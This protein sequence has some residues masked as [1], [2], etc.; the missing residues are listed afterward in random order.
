MAKF[1]RIGVHH[2]NVSGYTSKAWSVRRVGS[3]AVLKWGAV[4]VLGAGQ[5]RRIYWAVPPR[6]K[7]VRC[8]TEKRANGY[9]RK[10]ISRRL[11]H[12]YERLPESVPIRRRLALDNVD[13]ERKLATILFVDIVRS[14]EKAARMGD[15]RWSEV[16]NH[17]YAA[18]RRELR[19]A[20]GKE[21]TTT[22]DGMLAIFK[23]G[24]KAIRCASAIREAV[25]T[26]GLEI[27]AGLHAGEYQMIGGE[28]VGIAIHIGA[29]VA[30]K[31]GAS[32]L[33]VSSAV[34]N[35]VPKSGIK[36]KDRGVHRLKGVP[37]KW[38]LYMI[39]S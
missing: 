21:V 4:R 11:G 15:R 17:Y 20:S 28:V 39:D 29:R 6:Q 23:A 31:A 38:R 5:E 34:K 35:L 1:L 9:V 22:G 3:T 36:F 33:L 30:A 37:E 14:T 2:S 24:A 16:M 7:V 26:L 19:T 13:L 8:G 27:R 10:A 32:E 25:R 12:Q 18:V